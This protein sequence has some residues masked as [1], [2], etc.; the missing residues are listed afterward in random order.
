MS[1]CERFADLVKLLLSTLVTRRFLKLV[2]KAKHF[3]ERCQAA[4]LCA[5]K[6]RG[7]SRAPAI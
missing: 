3:V 6:K 5:M 7:R 2:L 4:S 1:F